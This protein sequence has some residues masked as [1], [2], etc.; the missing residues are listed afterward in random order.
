MLRVAIAGLGAIGRATA[1]RLA[2]GVPGLRLVCAAAND[3]AKAQAC[4]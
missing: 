1:R 2:E 3:H 4:A